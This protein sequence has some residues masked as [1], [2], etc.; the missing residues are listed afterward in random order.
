MYASLVRAA[1]RAICPLEQVP[2]SPHGWSGY[3]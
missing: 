3:L 2:R 1:R